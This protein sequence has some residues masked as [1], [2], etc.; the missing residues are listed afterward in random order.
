MY[1]IWNK[2]ISFDMTKRG[3]LKHGIG[4]VKKTSEVKSL[5]GSP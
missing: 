5:G 3:N 4:K 1:K 2:I